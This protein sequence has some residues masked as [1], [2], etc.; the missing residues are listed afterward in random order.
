MAPLGRVILSILYPGLGMILLVNERY[1]EISPMWL[2]RCKCS[3]MVSITKYQLREPLMK[4]KPRYV[5]PPYLDRLFCKKILFEYDKQLITA[6]PNNEV[7]RTDPSRSE[8]I[9]CQIQ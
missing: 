2:I 8:R 7:N 9:P 4:G 1:C 6:S 5:W 3:R